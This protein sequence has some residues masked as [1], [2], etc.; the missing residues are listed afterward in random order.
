MNKPLSMIVKETKTKIV[1]ACNESGLSPVIL[2]LIIQ[3]IY[4]DIHYL[5]EKQTTE[6]KMAYEKPSD[7]NNS[8]NK[9]ID[10][11]GD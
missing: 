4:T 7:K 10:V 11:D 1:N 2:D 8:I 3:G 6:E 5:A 9:I